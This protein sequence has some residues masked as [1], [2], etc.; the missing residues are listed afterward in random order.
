MWNEKF[1]IPLYKT[2]KIGSILFKMYDR[3]VRKKDF[4]GQLKVTIEDLVL[5]LEKNKNKC[6]ELR[7]EDDKNEVTA[8]LQLKASIQ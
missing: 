7:M 4:I 3:D 8:V 1:D 2:F 5:N 6:V